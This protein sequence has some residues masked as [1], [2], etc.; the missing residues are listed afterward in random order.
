MGTDGSP[1]EFF[2][3]NPHGLA[4]HEA[5]AAAIADLGPAT[6]RVTRSQI[7]FRRRKGFA[8]VWWPG[9]YIRSEVPA[10]LSVALPYPLESPR[11]KE[12]AHSAPR[13]WMH[14][15]ELHDVAEVDDEVRGWL[16]EAYAA[17]G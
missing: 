8:Y 17:A 5:V 3:G 15:L 11:F 9:R 2:E 7:A 4:L 13:V 14:H 1:E 16:A 10:V 6:A 12:I